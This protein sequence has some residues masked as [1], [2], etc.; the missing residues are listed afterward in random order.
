MRGFIVY[1]NIA[2]MIISKKKL[3]CA[4]LWVSYY[5]IVKKLGKSVEKKGAKKGLQKKC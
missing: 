1:F 2:K 3:Y 5:R 4:H